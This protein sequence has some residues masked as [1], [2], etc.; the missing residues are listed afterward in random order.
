MQSDLRKIKDILANYYKYSIGSS[1]FVG[2]DEFVGRSGLIVLDGI[3][4][5]DEIPPAFASGYCVV[6]TSRNMEIAEH[7]VDSMH[8]DGVSYDSMLDIYND[9][10]ARSSAA[11]DVYGAYYSV[12]GHP[13]LTVILARCGDGIRRISDRAE[14]RLCG[15]LGFINFIDSIKSDLM[16]NVVYINHAKS[17][18]LLAGKPIPEMMLRSVFGD[19]DY[20]EVISFMRSRDMVFF[21]ERGRVNLRASVQFALS[22]AC[23]KKER[24]LIEAELRARLADAL[25]VRGG[26]FRIWSD[27]KYV[28]LHARHVVRDIRGVDG[29]AAYVISRIV[30]CLLYFGRYG[31]AR[32]SVSLNGSKL[33]WPDSPT[34]E[35]AELR[36]LSGRASF[37]CGAHESSC[38]TFIAAGEW[39]ETLGM[40]RLMVSCLIWAGA[41][42]LELEEIGKRK[43]SVMRS[44]L[45]KKL[46]DIRAGDRGEAIDAYGAV[47]RASLFHDLVK[48]MGDELER[49]N[50]IVMSL[51]MDSPEAI[52]ACRRLGRLYFKAG[53]SAEAAKLFRFAEVA[54]REYW[55][56][57][58]P[59]F[60]E[61]VL[62]TFLADNA[63]SD[64][65]GAVWL[66]DKAVKIVKTRLGNRHPLTK[67]LINIVGDGRQLVLE[68]KYVDDEEDG[69]DIVI[70]GM[71]DNDP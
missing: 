19:V 36:F 70:D 61:S 54:A 14:K 17:L 29:V 43:F 33:F 39:A 44:K 5:V 31:K 24:S 35:L 34:Q 71:P 22:V 56:D 13:L 32:W 41:S 40:R 6:L 49:L 46:R 48:D 8:I 69:F 23:D 59:E 53:A 57:A 67:K 21:S 20:K 60:A 11:D 50:G 7:C 3:E 2:S 28:V 52:W 16:N 42:I 1:T 64:Q 47:V 30:D 38:R 37:A 58:H 63:L 4:S 55:G 15:D 51:A 68:D 18:S 12:G 62:D 45:Y 10:C 65:G 9:H 26:D 66:M 25:K 27:Y